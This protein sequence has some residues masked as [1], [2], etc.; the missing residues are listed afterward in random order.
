MVAMCRGCSATPLCLPRFCPVLHATACCPA[1][2]GACHEAMALTAAVTGRLRARAWR[3]ACAGSNNDH[4]RLGDNTTNNRG[5]PTVVS[6]GHSFAQVTAGFYHTCGI[7]TNGT[8][9]CWGE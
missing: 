3:D 9:L 7:R 8:A 2:S 4:G 5:L 1:Q 6:G